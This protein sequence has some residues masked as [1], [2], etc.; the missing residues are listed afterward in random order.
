MHLPS[1]AAIG[2]A[3]LIAVTGLTACS[4]GDDGA[5]S[6]NVDCAAANEAI[7]NYS[8]ALA[9]FV[10]G[11]TEENPDMARAGADAF[12]TAAT[13]IPRALPGVPAAA[14]SFVT[15]SEDASRLI[16]N[17]LNDGVS[18]EEILD[19]LNVLF[20]SE[21]FSTGGDAVDDYFRT[22]CPDEANPS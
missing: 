13:Q 11:L 3:S 21:E 5:A 14:E 8:T 1:F 18:G 10:Q 7:L 20:N 17:A 9:E 16:N 6:G 12:L 15:V 19:E 4:S 22:Q 2:A